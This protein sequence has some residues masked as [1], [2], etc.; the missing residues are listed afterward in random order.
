MPFDRM[1]ACHDRKDEFAFF[2]IERLADSAFVEAGQGFMEIDAVEYRGDFLRFD[3]HLDQ[4]VL[5][6]LRYG[7]QMVRTAH[8]PLVQDGKYLG[9][10]LGLMEK[11]ERRVAVNRD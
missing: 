3:P 1:E 7:K 5:E 11:V 2:R 9:K 4:H 10:R 8:R 6:F